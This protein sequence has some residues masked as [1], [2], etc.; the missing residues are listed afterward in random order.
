[1]KLLYFHT[2]M[3]FLSEL[4]GTI[5]VFIYISFTYKRFKMSYFEFT[6]MLL[7]GFVIYK[8]VKLIYRIRRDR[9]EI[10]DLFL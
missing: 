8:S 1:M 7:G 3:F 2:F 6:I 5:I 9:Q 4:S 10:R